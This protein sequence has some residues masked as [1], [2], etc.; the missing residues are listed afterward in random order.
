VPAVTA[1]AP[2]VVANTSALTA[3]VPDVVLVAVLVCTGCPNV[4][5]P[6]RPFKPTMKA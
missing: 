1:L 5:V 3:V 4:N 6:E 2:A